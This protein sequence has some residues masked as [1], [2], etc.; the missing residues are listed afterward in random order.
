[1]QSGVSKRAL[2]SE[3][4]GSRT[5][6]DANLA[7]GGAIIPALG[8]RHALALPKVISILAALNGDFVPS[9]VRTQIDSWPER[10]L[11]SDISGLARKSVRLG[12]TVA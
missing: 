6:L 7:M 12:K 1:M 3:P 8:R 10:S 5:V 4:R 9:T 11:R 2:F